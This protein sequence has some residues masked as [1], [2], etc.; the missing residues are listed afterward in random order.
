VKETAPAFSSGGVLAAAGTVDN[1]T[2]DA[3]AFV[4]ER[5]AL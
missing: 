2:Q 5:Q 3:F 4:G 1:W